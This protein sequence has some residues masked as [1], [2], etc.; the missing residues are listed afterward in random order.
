MERSDFLVTKVPFDEAM[1]DVMGG[2][3]R[4]EI[5]VHNHGKV[6]LI[7]VMPRFVPEMRAA[8]YAIAQAARVS[9]G[10]GQKSSSDDVS[11]IRHLFRNRHTS[12]FEMVEFKFF[13]RLPIFIARQWIRHRMANVN[14]A[15]GRYKILPREFFH[16][17]AEDLRQQ[18]KTNK[19]GGTEPLDAL[20]AAEF[21]AYLEKAE[22]LY[23]DYERLAD[24]GVSR[25]LAR[26]G[27]P[28]SLYTEW[29][30]KIDLHN[31]LHFLGLRMEAHAQKE[32]QD[33]AWAM[34]QLIQPIVPASCQAFLDYKFNAVTLSAPE[35]EA[36]KTGKSLEGYSSGEQREWEEKKKLLGQ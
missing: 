28:L 5:S 18:S 25:E 11:L 13:G 32:I 14:E 35:I 23:L 21:D 20:T 10:S 16:P 24:K 36:L 8:D 22:A 19:Q 29:Y 27:L 12:P 26:I 15:S 34:Y 33:Y 17:S 4:W 7:D 6:A 2:S 31:L 9:Y 3:S 30:W 1:V